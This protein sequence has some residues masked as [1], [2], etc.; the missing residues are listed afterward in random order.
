[1]NGIARR[2]VFRRSR[3]SGIARLK[4]PGPSTNRA[5]RSSSPTTGRTGP[6]SDESPATNRAT[7]YR[8]RSPEPSR[9]PVRAAPQALG[10]RDSSVIDNLAKPMS[11]AWVSGSADEKLLFSSSAIAGLRRSARR[12]QADRERPRREPPDSPSAPG[13]LAPA[14]ENNVPRESDSPVPERQETAKRPTAVF[15]CFAA[16]R[17]APHPGEGCRR[18]NADDPA[19]HDH[20]AA[21]AATSC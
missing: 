11:S 15:P 20:L 2:Y 4:M 5:E 21:R 16:G 1:M 6:R 13:R 8:R 7:G 19:V 18:R 3:P 10:S 12:T 17:Q 9:Q 14:Y